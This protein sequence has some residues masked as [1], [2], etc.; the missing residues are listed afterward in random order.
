MYAHDIAPATVD[1]VIDIIAGKEEEP[2]IEAPA[3]L[4]LESMV[5]TVEFSEID[6]LVEISDQSE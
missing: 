5:R 2:R 3:T 1:E 4:V 6:G